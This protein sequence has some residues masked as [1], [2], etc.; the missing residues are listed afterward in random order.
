MQPVD[1]S[2]EVIKDTRAVRI[3]SVF[4]M[5]FHDSGWKSEIE[6]QIRFKGSNLPLGVIIIIPGGFKGYSEGKSSFP[7]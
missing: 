3:V 1:I 5:G 2:S 7:W 6:R 4:Q